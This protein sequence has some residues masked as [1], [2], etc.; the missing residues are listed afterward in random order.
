MK[1]FLLATNNLGK[2]AE[3]RSM[4]A[5]LDLA[6]V[7]LGDLPHFDEV[8]ETAETFRG[9][10]A[11]KAIGY[12]RQSGII[13]LADDSGLE[14]N[15]LGGQ[16]GVYSARYGGD[17]LGFDEKMQMLLDEM[18]K[19]GSSDRSARFACSVAIATPNGEILLEA[20][21]FC[22]GQIAQ[23]PRG[24]GGFGYDPLFVPD[25]HD[26]TF[27]ELDS[28]VKHKISHRAAAFRQIIP[29]LGHFNVV[30]T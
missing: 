9:N 2:V 24:S 29:F 7:G 18:A 26:L 27:G 14:V 1:Q 30:S 28:S 23:E 8:P 19:T 17:H 10:A 20:E 22:T 25:G 4:I 11:L 16:P 15:A 5:G 21:G 6:I 12:A 3:M 13:A